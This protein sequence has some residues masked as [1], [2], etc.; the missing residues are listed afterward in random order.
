MPSGGE[1]ACE[2]NDKLE[3][4]MG[5]RQRETPRINEAEKNEAKSKIFIC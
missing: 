3:R 4:E 5:S 1:E 2:E